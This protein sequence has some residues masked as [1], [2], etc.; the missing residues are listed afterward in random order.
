MLLWFHIPWSFRASWGFRLEWDC[1]ECTSCVSERLCFG[2]LLGFV[3]LLCQC[4]GS[5]RHA[6]VV[7]YVLVLYLAGRAFT[8]CGWIPG[9]HWDCCAILDCDFCAVL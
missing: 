6:W 4:L 8:N 3:V 7:A 9:L 1:D 2:L 5:R